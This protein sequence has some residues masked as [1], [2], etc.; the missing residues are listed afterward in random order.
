M[1]DVKQSP[2][3]QVGDKVRLTF[4]AR[5][6]GTVTEVRR[7]YSPGGHIMYRIRIPMTPEPLWV[8]AREDEVEKA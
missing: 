3:H 2:R 8:E 6:A 4:G 5:L 7:A 1:P